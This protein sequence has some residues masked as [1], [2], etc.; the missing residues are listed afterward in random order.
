MT[1]VERAIERARGERA[2]MKRTR[3]DSRERKNVN[4]A[5]TCAT[6]ERRIWRITREGR[7]EETKTPD[8]LR[9]NN[10]STEPTSNEKTRTPHG[11]EDATMRLG[12]RAWAT[13]TRAA[14][15]G[16]IE[17]IGPK[18]GSCE[19]ETHWSVGASRGGR[20]ALYMMMASKR[21]KRAK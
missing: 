20:E 2:K 12:K 5:C 1:V 17:S 6:A 13:L 18:S 4:P 3:P 19:R 7:K 10:Q 9:T 15:N 8:R 16:G 14:A 11:D 21:S